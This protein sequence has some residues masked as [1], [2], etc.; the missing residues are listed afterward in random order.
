MKVRLAQLS[1]AILTGRRP[2]VS[3]HT[4]ES[5]SMQRVDLIV[6]RTFKR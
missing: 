3:Y 1:A 5:G 6:L 4:E 2:K